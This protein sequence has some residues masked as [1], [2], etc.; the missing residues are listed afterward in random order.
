MITVNK[1]F[2]GGNNPFNCYIHN[3]PPANQHS[4]TIKCAIILK[5][6]CTF[7]TNAV[8]I[9]VSIFPKILY[10]GMTNGCYNDQ[11]AFKELLNFYNLNI[12]QHH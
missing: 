5:K 12:S 7:D 11:L 8:L 3:S 9:F 1:S 6:N 4:D 10:V 2:F